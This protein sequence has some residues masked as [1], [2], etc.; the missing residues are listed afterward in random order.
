MN[1]LYVSRGDHIDYQDDCLFLGLKEHFGSSV[2]DV[3]KRYHCYTT[4]DV[5]K[6]KGLYGKGF[7]VTKILEEDNTDRTDIV[8]K[9]KAQFFDYIIYGSINRCTDFLQEAT[10]VYPKKKIILVDGE[11]ETTYHPLFAEKY[12][13]F[14]REKIH[15]DSSFPISFAIPTSKIQPL[16]QKTK[17]IAHILPGDNS[18]YIFNNEQDYYNDYSMSRYGVTVKRSGW[19]CMRHYEILANNCVPLFFDI[20]KCPQYTLTMFPKLKAYHLFKDCLTTKNGN[21]F[22]DT[23]LITDADYEIIQDFFINFTKNYLTTYALAERVINKI[24]YEN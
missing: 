16:K 21:M 2:V 14:K 13:Y 15:K 9:I 8:N 19:D 5:H 22:L 10:K 11:D 17:E 24:K 7:T 12:P 23:G 3:N 1:I 20:D 6:L 4:Y 18:T